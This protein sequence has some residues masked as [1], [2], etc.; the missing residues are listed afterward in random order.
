MS[1]IDLTAD[2]PAP[3][4]D[5]PA[6]LRQDIIDE[7]ADHLHCALQRELLTGGGRQSP[8]DMD[9]DQ[10]STNREAHASRS[11][12]HSPEEY[13]R[14]IVLN[15]F[16]NPAAIARR[17]WLDAMKERLMA[18]KLMTVMVT[19]AALACVAMVLLMWRTMETVRQQ[20]AAMLAEHNAFNARLLQ[21]L[22]SRAATPAA[23]PGV[24]GW[25]PLK[26]R[27][28][29]ADGNPV[30]GKV[31]LEG[32][33]I[34]AGNDNKVSVDK[35]AGADGSADF[36]LIPYGNYTMTLT[37][38]AAQE[39]HVETF[40]LAPGQPSDREVICPDQPR[41]PASLT[42]RFNPPP[43]IRAEDLVYGVN[44][45]IPSR[46]SVSG[47]WKFT[48]PTAYSFLVDAT[49]QVLGTADRTHPMESSFG[50]GFP[51]QSRSSQEMVHGLSEKSPP[52]LRAYTYHLEAVSVFARV[53]SARR[54]TCRFSRYG[55]GRNQALHV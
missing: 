15:R 18:Q 32:T 19:V 11:P 38:P 45:Q 25:G 42:F 2:L 12:G 30:E 1:D 23:A 53:K 51:S 28:V 43:E 8:D 14:Q 16:G 4:D 3:R 55:R 50:G 49:G 27:L 34:N 20:Q 47:R 24:D 5:E 7:L 9:G 54:A 6:S 36:G 13:A 31:A 22:Q 26:I 52:V 41:P 35:T 39:S 37:V 44:L 17:L 40:M 21:E 10:N 29:S 46:D 48:G 33:A